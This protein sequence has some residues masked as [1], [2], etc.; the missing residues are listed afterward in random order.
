MTKTGYFDALR[1]AKKAEAVPKSSRFA[2]A[3]FGLALVFIIYT[4]LNLSNPKTEAALQD[5]DRAQMTANAIAELLA[6]G[7]IHDA[8]N[9]EPATEAVIGC[10]VKPYAEAWPDTKSARRSELALW[11]TTRRPGLQAQYPNAPIARSVETYL[12]G[13]KRYGQFV[14][15][16]VVV[17]C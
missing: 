3:G 13:T 7:E 5:P 9:F 15:V 1:A 12:E 6:R 8:N 2:L 4:L 14:S 11:Q 16:Y 10:D 17:D